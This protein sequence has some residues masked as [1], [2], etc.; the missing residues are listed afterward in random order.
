MSG[1]RMRR[2]LD[3]LPNSGASRP[4]LSIAAYRT[5]FR[6]DEADDE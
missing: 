4:E 1:S 6:V 3:R 5:A 2:L